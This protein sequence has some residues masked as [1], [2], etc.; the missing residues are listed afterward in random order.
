MVTLELLLPAA[1]SVTPLG[2]ATL[3]VFVTEPLALADTVP[4][5]VTVRVLPLP[6]FSW[7]LGKVTALPLP[8][9]PV[10]AAPT[11]QSPTRLPRTS[12]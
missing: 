7:A 10:P 11:S 3:A 5:I 4:L 12:R 1:G 8:F 9:P 2:A 6:A